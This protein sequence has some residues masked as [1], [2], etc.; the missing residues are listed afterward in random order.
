MK[1]DMIHGV[2][3]LVLV[4]KPTLSR[5][6]K[7]ITYIII[8]RVSR[9][10]WKDIWHKSDNESQSSNLKHLSVLQSYSC[11]IATYRIISLVGEHVDIVVAISRD[12]CMNQGSMC[13]SHF[14]EICRS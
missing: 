1:S 11:V 8:I 3:R 12:I 4:T 2:E 7:K 13:D 5:E 6:R 10:M 14:D 9:E